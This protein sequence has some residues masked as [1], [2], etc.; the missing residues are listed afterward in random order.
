MNMSKIIHSLFL[1]IA[2]AIVYFIVGRLGLLLDN[3]SGY[4]SPI[5]P[6]AG[7]ALAGLIFFG[8]RILPGVF[9]GSFITNLPADIGVFSF[10]NN[11]ESLGIPLSIA[12]GSTI[13]ALVGAALVKRYVDLNSGLLKSKDIFLFFIFAGPLSC[14][15]SSSWGVNTLF[16]SEILSRHDYLFSLLTWWVGD[17]MGVLLVVPLLLILFAKPKAVWKQRQIN[18]GIP[19]ILVFILTVLLFLVNT[20]QEDKRLNS[21]FIRQ[22]S[23][24]NDSLDK[25]LANNLEVIYSVHSFF[26]SSK[27][28]HAEDFRRFLQETL[29]RHPSIHAIS[30][31][32]VVH[33][34]QRDQF[35]Q[36]MRRQG[37]TDFMIKEKIEGS[38]VIAKE[39]KKYV[40][41]T[42]I[43]PY[44]GNEKAVGYDVY[45]NDARRMAMDL[46]SA[47]G[48]LTA[49]EP[50]K[51]I[52]ETGSQS[53]V[54]FFLPLY[55]NVELSQSLSNGEK[56]LKGYIV[57]VYRTGDLLLESLKNFPLNNIVV[58]LNDETDQ[59]NILPIA[60]Y[61]FDRNGKLVENPVSIDDNHVFQAKKDIVIAEKIWT[62]NIYATPNYSAGHRSVFTW[63]VLLGSLLF[64]TLLELFLM[65]LTGRAILFSNLAKELSNEVERSKLLEND[66]IQ[67]NE[68]LENRVKERTTD[69]H[70]AIEE[71]LEAKGVAETANKSKSTFLANMSHEIRT[72]MNAILGFVDQLNKTET[73]PERQQ[74]LN[75]IKNSGKTLLNIINDILDFSKIETGKM[76]LD[77]HSCALRPLLDETKML[78]HKDF[79]NKEIDFK[80]NVSSGIPE[81][82][83]TDT[84]RVKQV[85]LNLLGN[86]L[87]FTPQKGT[88]S[89]DVYYDKDKDL[90]CFSVSDTGIGIAQ[91]NQ[92]K[93]F[94]AFDQEDNSITRKFGGSGLGLAIS[95]KLVAMM[96]GELKVES[97]LGTGSRF[98]F[99]IPY[100]AC[101]KET[102]KDEVDAATDEYQSHPMLSG[103]VLMVED[104]KTNQML[105]GMILDDLGMTFDTANDG[106]EAVAMYQAKYNAIL[107]DE[108]M[109]NMDGI[110]ATRHI[111]EIEREKNLPHVPIIAVTANAL[112]EDRQRFLDAG[113]D[114]YVS[115][116]YTEDDIASTLKKL[117]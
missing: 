106:V 63:V 34:L 39:R 108:N 79:K 6:A 102:V 49:T 24:L 53:G 55:E 57:G 86:A 71:A 73:D 10:S 15:I 66:L 67:V 83:Y 35:E 80:Y 59:N 17:T 61:A 68:N 77:Q 82:I 32:P 51:L 26:K 12:V 69:L 2:L 41:V 92:E 91:A 19:M 114:E 89:F 28:I 113:F 99:D 48:K 101:Q 84:I 107:M 9:I 94:N 38:V 20:K 81:C 98:Y 70:I 33:S 97:K 52:Q 43:E 5:W 104:N 115:K 75:I 72:P 62:L 16:V 40:V 29:Q 23:L 117:L 45:S 95:S 31:N 112:S 105:L 21:E 1:I 100:V 93:I 96:G 103:H 13:Q 56:Q 11:V 27:T 111:R 54:L 4:V 37:Y 110:E 46:A 116:P 85:L 36:E 87:K 76:S 50:I 60:T 18:M 14:L 88:V 7:F 47:L 8:Y 90:I 25:N 42:Y 44:V 109:P 3:P 22:A 65:L 30:W 58:S 78:L 64:A 74:Y